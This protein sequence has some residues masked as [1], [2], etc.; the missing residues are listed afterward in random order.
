MMR[1]CVI[2]IVWSDDMLSIDVGVTSLQL[3]LPADN[4]DVVI[5]DLVSALSVSV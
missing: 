5:A 2:V 3:L 1:D 4:G